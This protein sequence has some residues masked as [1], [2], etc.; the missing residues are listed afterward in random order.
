MSPVTD[1]IFVD[2]LKDDER[3]QT[4]QES[5]MNIA[6]VLSVSFAPEEGWIEVKHEDSLDIGSICDKLTELGYPETGINDAI[7]TAQSYFE[8]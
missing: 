5:L 8:L 2:N 6:G 7:Q 3:V 1:K 4:I